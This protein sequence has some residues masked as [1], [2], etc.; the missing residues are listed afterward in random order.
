MKID[1]MNG[2]K[3][4]KQNED[5]SI[6]MVRIVWV[7]KPMNKKEVTDM[8]IYDYDTKLVSKV[9]VSDYKDYTPLEPDGIFTCAVVTIENEGTM[10]TDVMSTVTHY[11]KLKS[12]Q[13]MMPYAVCRQ[14][15]TDVFYN[16]IATNP[17]KLMVGV[18]I[19]Q[20]T[21][22]ANFDFGVMFAASSIG[23][24]DFVNFYINDTL[25]DIYELIN[26]K[27]YDDVLRDNYLKHLHHDQNMSAAFAQEDYGWCKNLKTL[28]DTNNYQTDI[29]MML[30]VTS[31]DFGISEFVDIRVNESG[32]SY[33]VANED[34]KEWLSIQYKVPIKEATIIEYDHDVDLDKLKA[35]YILMRDMYK[36]L[37]VI[38]YIADGEFFEDDLKRKAEEKDFTTKFKLKYYNKYNSYNKNL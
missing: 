23:Y 29:D 18:S 34:F 26:V 28:F 25:D 27:K 2:Y 36:K 16:L 7:N 24:N 35:S 17:D 30:G 8:K 10:A 9:K 31:V 21:C 14:N 12:R 6:H 22:P 37:Y 11:R 38:V 4:F 20:D 32:N 19:S 33:N 13:N 3:L 1:N 5:G 15:I